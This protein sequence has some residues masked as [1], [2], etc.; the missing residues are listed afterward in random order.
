MGQNPSR[1]SLDRYNSLRLSGRSSP[2]DKPATVRLKDGTKVT[3]E[4][5]CSLYARRY[6]GEDAQQLLN[7]IETNFDRLL[8]TKERRDS[9]LKLSKPAF[10]NVVKSDDL[11]AVSEYTLLLLVGAWVDHQI[12][13]KQFKGISCSDFFVD[14]LISRV[15]YFLK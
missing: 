2:E 10:M 13:K 6:K 3:L 8:R 9:F 1:A 11:Y 15:L 7:V 14:S 4:N 5:V 12:E